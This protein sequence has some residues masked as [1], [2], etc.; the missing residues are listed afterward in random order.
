MHILHDLVKLGDNRAIKRD[1][2]EKTLKPDQKG[3]AIF[4]NRG[5]GK[6][7]RYHTVL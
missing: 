7:V 4:P 3:F 2:A 6:G 5:D 1:I